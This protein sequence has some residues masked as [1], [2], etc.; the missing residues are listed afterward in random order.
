MGVAG[1]GNGAEQCRECNLASPYQPES[2]L[3]RGQTCPVTA[4]E[5]QGSRHARSRTWPLSGTQSQACLSACSGWICHLSQ[6]PAT[7]KALP[8]T[9][10]PEPP[11]EETK[12]PSSTSPSVY[13]FTNLLR[14]FDTNPGTDTHTYMTNS[15]P[16]CTVSLLVTW[17]FFY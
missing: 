10:A 8:T 5:L 12:H 13:C 4:L 9:A 15:F 7:S 1:T 3:E 6:S 17:G 14:S 11:P 16:G 2:D